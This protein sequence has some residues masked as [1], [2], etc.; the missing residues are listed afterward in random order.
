MMSLMRFSRSCNFI[1]IIFVIAG[2]VFASK[3]MADWKAEANARIEHLR[4]RDV[5]VQVISTQ[6]HP[7][8]DVSI[9]IRQ[10]RQAFPFGSA[11]SRTLLRNE[12]YA[13]F[14][15]SHFNWAAFE[16]E[17]K[18]YSNERVQGRDDYRDADAMLAWCQANNIPVRGHCVFWEPERWQ[19]RW[20]RDLAQVR[21]LGG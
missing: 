14:F 2:T 18:W 4:Q 15:K 17:S 13:E 20:L 16:N 12:R 11:M 5:E 1:V 9:E 21:Q 8:K 19:P 7:A 3:A 10:V 6:G